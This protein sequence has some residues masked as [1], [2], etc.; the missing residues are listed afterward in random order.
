M[1]YVLLTYLLLVLEELNH[2]LAMEVI[3][4]VPHLTYLELLEVFLSSFLFLVKKGFQ[5]E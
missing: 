1:I 3:L 4:R 2:P 5:I